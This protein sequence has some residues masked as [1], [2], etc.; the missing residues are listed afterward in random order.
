LP[1]IVP[2][3]DEIKTSPSRASSTPASDDDEVEK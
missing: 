2:S 3:T 1:P